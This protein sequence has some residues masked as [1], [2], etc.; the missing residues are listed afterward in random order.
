MNMT[1]SAFLPANVSSEID[2]PEATSGSEKA[3]A[4]VPNSS[5]VDGVADIFLL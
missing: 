5:I 4:F 3:G 2:F 1:S